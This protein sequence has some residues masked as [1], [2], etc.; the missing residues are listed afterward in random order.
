MKL[1]NSTHGR[2]PSLS[3]GMPRGFSLRNTKVKKAKKVVLLGRIDGVSVFGEI[4]AAAVL[5][6][7]IKS[8]VESVFRDMV[9]MYREHKDGVIDREIKWLTTD[10]GNL[11]KIIISRDEAISRG[12]SALMNSKR[13]GRA[14]MISCLVTWVSLG[15]VALL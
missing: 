4:R 8:Y 10:N 9:E 11:A 7:P 12:V 6:Q 14:W 2:F 15:I 13:V 5:V 3:M 1:D